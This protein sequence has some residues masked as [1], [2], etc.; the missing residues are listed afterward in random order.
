MKKTAINRV[1][2][3]AKDL[4][5]M[6]DNP[7]LVGQEL[8]N[9]HQQARQ[10]D[11]ISGAQFIL[12]LEEDSSDAMYNA[13]EYATKEHDRLHNEAKEGGPIPH[14]GVWLEALED[15]LEQ[16]YILIKKEQ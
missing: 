2:K 16:N 1:K 6:T 13:V 4:F 9:L 8:A 15:Y 14:E 11:F 7:R 12:S 5:P 10:V 3:E